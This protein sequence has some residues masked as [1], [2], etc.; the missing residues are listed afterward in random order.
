MILKKM[1]LLSNNDLYARI[2]EVEGNPEEVKV[3]SLEE[4]LNSVAKIAMN[5]C[6]VAELK[7]L[8]YKIGLFHDL[9]KATKSWQEYLKQSYFGNWSSGKLDH[10]TLGGLKIEH[11]LSKKEEQ[12][13]CEIMELVVYSHHGMR[14][15]LNEMGESIFDIRRGKQNDEYKNILKDEKNNFQS[16]ILINY[17]LSEKS[18]NKCENSY[19]AGALYRY[20]LSLLVDADRTDAACAA[21]SRPNEDLIVKQDFREF[22]DKRISQYEKYIDGF[23]SKTELDKL[24]GRISKVCKLY[25]DNSERLIR[26]QSFTGSGKTLSSLRFA[27]Y[28]AKK[29]NNR[30]IIV[31][32]PYQ[33]IL[34][35]TYHTYCEIFGSDNVLLHHSRVTFESEELNIKYDILTEN[36]QNSPI[37]LTTMVQLLNS[38]FKSNLRD[39]RRFHSLA[40]SVLIIDEVQSIPPNIIGLFN[41]AMNFL[42]KYLNTTVVLCSATHPKF[43]DDNMGNFK[44]SHS[45]DWDMIPSNPNLMLKRK[46]YKIVWD[47]WNDKLVSMNIQETADLIEKRLIDNH[48]KNMLVVVNTKGAANKLYHCLKEKNMNYT[49]YLLTTN[50]YPAERSRI[51]QELKEKLKTNEK[52]ICVSTQLIEAG[53]DLS[54]V[55]A[56]R[57]LAGMDNILQIAGR[58]NRNGEIDCGL[59]QVIK[60]SDKDENISKIQ[61]IKQ[62][63][64]IMVSVLSKCSDDMENS[65]LLLDDY[66]RKYNIKFKDEL[67]Y[68]I[69]KKRKNDYESVSEF[70]SVN[71]QAVSNRRSMNKKMQILSQSFKTAGDLFEVIDDK[72]MIPLVVDCDESDALINEYRISKSFRKKKDIIRRLQN[73]IVTVS[74]FTVEKLDEQGLIFNLDSENK[75]NI[76][77]LNRKGYDSEIGVQPLDSLPFICI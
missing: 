47:C 72:N 74:K 50:I 14:D 30:H 41:W 17:L 21:G 25:A 38:I 43:D 42:T 36:Y 62:Q 28:R 67:P 11:D 71:R 53:V 31:V 66:Y 1:D 76:L 65:D 15:A 6:D 5:I 64:D 52:I 24:R 12:L 77:I 59:V 48:L 70:L 3:Q 75:H 7:E 44:L 40:N 63:Q 8:A 10:S 49:I 9:G 29:E 73:Y 37:V 60:I 55:S 54:F 33:S 18:D 69:D 2:S 32:A 61:Y 68:P 23:Q 35:Q 34:D 22:W 46:R 51:I 19:Y 13:D 20:F 27:L 57:S 4:H 58:C 39:V 26:L 16:T 56:M 45:K